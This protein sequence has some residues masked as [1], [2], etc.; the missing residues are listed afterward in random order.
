MSQRLTEYFT[1]LAST[2]RGKLNAPSGTKYTP[3]DMLE[4]I[5]E[6]VVANLGSWTDPETG[7]TEV[8]ANGTYD[9]AGYE[10]I[11][12][13]IDTAA[14]NIPGVS[15]SGDG[16]LTVMASAADYIGIT[17]SSLTGEPLLLSGSS[18]NVT[19]SLSNSTI[20]ISGASGTLNITNGN[21]SSAT[22]TTD[23][24]VASNIKEGVKILGVTGTLVEVDVDAILSASY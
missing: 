20:D 4:Y 16:R 2:L 12:V 6:M 9:V 15:V 18:S 5:D 24:L 22:I 8:T 14:D 17:V 10:S 7:A 19:Y 3:D 21:N 13:N 11:T 1:S 23:N